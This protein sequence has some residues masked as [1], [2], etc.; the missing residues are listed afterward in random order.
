MSEKYYLFDTSAKKCSTVDNGN[1]AFSVPQNDKKSKYFQTKLAKKNYN[2]WPQLSLARH[3]TFDST[4][5]IEKARSAVDQATKQQMQRSIDT[6]THKLSKNDNPRG[7]RSV[8]NRMP[9]VQ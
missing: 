7:V 9:S 6:H 3:T 2:P 5:S 1:K 8:Q 4:P